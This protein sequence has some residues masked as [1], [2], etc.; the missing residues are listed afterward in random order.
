[1]ENKDVLKATKS[2]KWKKNELRPTMQTPRKCKN[3]FLLSI[4]LEE[5]AEAKDKLAGVQDL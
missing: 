2:S 3:W 4:A 5:L 1:M